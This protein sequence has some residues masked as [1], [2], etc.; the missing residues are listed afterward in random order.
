MANKPKPPQKVKGVVIL[1]RVTNLEK[2]KIIARANKRG[3]KNISEYLRQL[4]NED[5][6]NRQMDVIV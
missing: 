1:F 3:C 2:A 4:I 6:G 5:K